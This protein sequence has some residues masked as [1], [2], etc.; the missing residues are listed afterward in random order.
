MELPG[1]AH[2]AR[3]VLRATS[4]RVRGKGSE[5][6]TG[7]LEKGRSRD[8]RGLSVHRGRGVHGDAWVVCG[9]FEREGSNRR[10]PWVNES[11]GANGRP[12]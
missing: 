11:G 1:C 9:R 10:D 3:R 8:G 6:G 4:A 2:G 12:G 5:W 7:Q